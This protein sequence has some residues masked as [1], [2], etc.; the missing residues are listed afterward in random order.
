LED[1][2]NG[3]FTTTNKTFQDQINNDNTEITATT[4]RIATMQN[5]LVAQM[6]A[7]DSLIASLQ[8]QVSYY[9]TLFQDTQ[10][11]TKNG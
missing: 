6:S 9:T 7:A 4:A 2:S 1:S 10:N 11:A 5:Q 3:L 8:N